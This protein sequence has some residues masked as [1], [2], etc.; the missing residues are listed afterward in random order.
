MSS[1]DVDSHFC[2]PNNFH[3]PLLV[4][5]E[6]LDCAILSATEIED[7]DLCSKNARINFEMGIERPISIPVI[8]REYSVS[9]A[10]D[11]YKAE[12]AESLGVAFDETKLSRTDGHKMHYTLGNIGLRYVVLKYVLRLEILICS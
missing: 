3:T 1:D 4:A 8:I 5:N 7:T 12:L 9:I 10:L 11:K 2:V 6:F